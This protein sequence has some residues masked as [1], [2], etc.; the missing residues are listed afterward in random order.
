MIHTFCL[1]ALLGTTSKEPAPFE[2]QVYDMYGNRVP[3]VSVWIGEE[4]TWRKPL[5]FGITNSEGVFRSREMY[6]TQL[7]ETGPNKGLH[8]VYVGLRGLSENR[9]PGP[10]LVR[11]EPHTSPKSVNVVIPDGN[12]N[13]PRPLRPDTQ[14]IFTLRKYRNNKTGEI[15][16]RWDNEIEWTEAVKVTDASDAGQGQFASLGDP[17]LVSRIVRRPY[18][19]REWIRETVPELDPCQVICNPCNP[20]R[21]PCCIICCVPMNPCDPCRFA[22]PPCEA[23]CETSAILYPPENPPPPPPPPP[24]RR[25][26]KGDGKGNDGKG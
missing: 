1:I 20:C 24:K 25:G 7:R 16:D 10:V 19:T 13:L 5:D 17:R 3:N 21:N 12:Q 15:A 18:D 8:A 11:W 23:I 6:E 14:L 22:C 9:L 2:V 26:G 4:R